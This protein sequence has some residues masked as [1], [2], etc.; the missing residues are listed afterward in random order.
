MQGNEPVCM[1]GVRRL[2]K[3]PQRQE[4]ARRQAPHLQM[5]RKKP[6]RCAFRIISPFS[7]RIAFMNWNSQMEASAR[8]RCIHMY[9]CAALV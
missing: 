1:Q 6:S 7:S 2:L 3:D 9:V 4:A 5:R 8:W